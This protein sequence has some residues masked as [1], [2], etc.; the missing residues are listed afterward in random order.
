MGTTPN[1]L[2]PTPPASFDLLD[3]S[4]GFAIHGVD[5][6]DLLGFVTSGAADV[7]GD[8]LDDLVI[9]AAGADPNGI[10]DAGSTYVIFGKPG[11][12]T[13]VF[14]PA[15]LDGSNGFRVDG[16]HSADQAAWP[17][18]AGDID[19]DGF[20]DIAIGAPNA[21][22][23]GLIDAGAGYTVLG[24]DGVFPATL[25]L[26]ELDGSNGYTVT[27]TA[28]DGH[29]GSSVRGIGDINGDGFHD[30]AFSAPNL[31]IDAPPATYVVFGSGQGFFA[32][33]D[34]ATLDGSNGFRIDGSESVADLGDINDDGL[35]DIMIGG[36]P[37]TVLFGT[38]QG[39]PAVVDISAVNG[40]NGF[41]I[42]GP[43]TGFFGHAVS[44]AGDINGDGVNDLLIGDFIA[45]S[46][47]GE[48]YV[49]FGSPNGFSPNFDVA[50]LDGSNGFR[51]TGDPSTQAGFSLSDTGDINGDGVDDILVGKKQFTTPDD[52]MV[53]I[54]GTAQGFGPVFEIPSMAPNQGFRVFST[55]GKDDGDGLTLGHA[56]DINGDGFDEI[57]VGSVFASPDSRTFGGKAFAIFGNDFTACVTNQGSA[58]N[59][60]MIG[61]AGEDIMLGGLGNDRLNG[62]GGPDVLKGGAGNDVLSVSDAL[63]RRLD[64]GG[65]TDTLRVSGFDLDLTTV[66]DARISGI[67]IIDLGD[68]KENQ[69]TLAVR[70]LRNLSDTSNTITVIGDAGDKVVIDLTGTGLQPVDQGAGFIAYTEQATNNGVTLLVQDSLDHSG[71]LF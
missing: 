4:N 32:S 71:I 65:G 3:G 64:G 60:T 45:A 52:Y 33:T 69:L 17:D 13:P 44:G 34:L 54:Y 35:D 2:T 41:K 7:N 63:F 28:A 9:P 18:T 6:L 42:S 30:V 11:G 58:G 26:S 24:S 39:F 27:G 10:F 1:H 53:V 48:V 62:R 66:P 37:S 14:D 50:T 40:I 68:A 22:A 38:D 25:I 23:N 57:L 31:T 20:A 21:D 67:E 51:I 70:D 49:V 46:S 29:L 16:I 55:D 8:G 12:Y 59:D 36:N 56:G 15:I 61:A 19:G 5:E 47:A 43:T